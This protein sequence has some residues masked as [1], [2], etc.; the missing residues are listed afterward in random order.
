M[1]TKIVPLVKVLWQYHDVR[2]A[3][4]KTEEKMGKLHPKLFANSGTNF[5]D[6]I[7]F[8]RAECETLEHD[9]S[10]I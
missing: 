6:E 7:F 1:R 3:T 4:W 9:Y 8:R 5:E 2:E 10:S